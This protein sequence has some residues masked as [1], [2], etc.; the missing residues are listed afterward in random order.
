MF[1]LGDLY[2][3][4]YAIGLSNAGTERVWSKTP[5]ASLLDT[6]CGMSYGLLPRRS[7]ISRQVNVS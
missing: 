4:L 2:S 7:C 5:N 1:T 6:L 3:N